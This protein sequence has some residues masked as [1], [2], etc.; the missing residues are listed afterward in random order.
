[1]VVLLTLNCAKLHENF[2][3]SLESVHSSR[4]GLLLVRPSRDVSNASLKAEGTLLELPES[5]VTHSHVLKC[6]ES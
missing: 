6:D 3:F 1:M 5:L 2:A 4:D